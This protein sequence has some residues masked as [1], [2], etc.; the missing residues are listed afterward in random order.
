MPN[1]QNKPVILYTSLLY[2]L[3][4]LCAYFKTVS[5]G[6]Q[7]RTHYIRYIAH[8]FYITHTQNHIVVDWIALWRRQNYTLLL[9]G[10]HKHEEQHQ[11]NIK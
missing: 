1:T 8:L 9:L 10:K 7:T 5:N 3:S 6:A 4:A 11:R 2:N